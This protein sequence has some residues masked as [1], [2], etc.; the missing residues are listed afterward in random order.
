MDISND[1]SLIIVIHF[2]R[3]L[4]NIFVSITDNVNKQGLCVL[5]FLNSANFKY[6]TIVFI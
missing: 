3:N 6:S 2:E 1:F 4:L 5:R